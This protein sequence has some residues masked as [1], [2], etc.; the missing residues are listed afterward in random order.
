[1][2]FI[3]ISI[4]MF[5]LLQAVVAFSTFSQ[6]RCPV[7]A[8]PGSVACLPDS[9]GASPPRPIGEWIKTWGSIVTSA[10]S[11]EAWVSIGKLSQEDADT[12][13]LED[14]RRSGVSDCK[15]LLS[16]RNQCSALAT[17]SVATNRTAAAGAPTTSLA[18]GDALRECGRQGGRECSVIYSE[19]TEPIFKKF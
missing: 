6:T 3:K 11:S 19:C 10:G 16:Y 12:E 14:C 9:D 1:M 8:T 13:A 2:K 18:K 17:S 4:G 5:F 15:V 7:G